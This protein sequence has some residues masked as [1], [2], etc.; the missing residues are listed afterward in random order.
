MVHVIKRKGHKEEFDEKK[1]YGSVYA[2]C[3]NVHLQEQE[4]ELIADQVTEELK[5]W[6]TKKDELSSRDIFEFVS[7]TLKKYNENAS[8]MYET[9][10]DLS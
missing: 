4:A 10:R 9:H 3:L 1:A 8:F 6:L 7:K 2:A 5:K